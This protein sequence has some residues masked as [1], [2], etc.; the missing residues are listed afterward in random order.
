[1]QVV[2]DDDSALQGLTAGV[3]DKKVRKKIR[4]IKKK[5]RTYIKPEDWQNNDYV[6]SPWFK[7]LSDIPLAQQRDQIRRVDA[8]HCS[9]QE[10]EREYE[11]KLLPT[12]ITH[13]MDHWT[14]FERW[15]LPSLLAMLGRYK[16]RCGEDDDGYPMKIRFKY[17]LHYLLTNK[18]DAPLYMFDGFFHQRGRDKV[19]T[20]QRHLRGG[21]ALM[22]DYDIPKYFRADLLQYA[23]AKNRPPYRWFVLGPARSGTNMHQDPLGTAAW[24]ALV[25]GYKRWVLFPP[26]APVALI[27]PKPKD[28]DREAIT[29]FHRV[30]PKMLEKDW[31]GPTPIEVIQG[32]GEVMYVPPNWWHI[33]LNLTH[34]VAITQNFSSEQSFA[35]QFKRV[36]MGRPNLC[37]HWLKKLEKHGRSD[38]LQVAKEVDR[39]AFKF[40]TIFDCPKEWRDSLL[41]YSSASSSDSS[42]T[43]YDSSDEAAGGDPS[44]AAIAAARKRKSSPSSTGSSVGSGDDESEDKEKKRKVR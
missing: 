6:N 44:P 4:K 18:D 15:K 22:K 43:I 12:V 7:Q 30:Y 3:D 34:T 23:G 32:P 14:A 25:S 24:N 2:Q 35:Y 10:F 13:A 20:D 31:Q 37:R 26:D 8:R 11:R 42:T 29:W 38:L 40:E 17:F 39:G 21:C 5:Q 9:P 28:G 19:A 16:F 41:D 1:M 36:K 27:K 33:V